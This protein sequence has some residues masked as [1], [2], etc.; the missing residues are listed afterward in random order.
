[1]LAPI[2]C[3]G[4]CIFPQTASD[5]Q[6]GALSLLQNMLI[7]L[8]HLRLS[9]S[10]SVFKVKQET[11]FPTV[12]RPCPIFI[13]GSLICLYW[14]ALQHYW[15]PHQPITIL[16]KQ[17]A[18]QVGVTKEK[19]QCPLDLLIV[20]MHQVLRQTREVV[21]GSIRLRVTNLSL[22]TKEVEQCSQP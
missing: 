11:L 16:F 13:A 17:E 12:P 21:S 3:G 18:L 2:N 10:L 7:S 15:C 22:S 9:S 8:L 1:M 14:R 5:W 6:I 20:L 19:C 4:R